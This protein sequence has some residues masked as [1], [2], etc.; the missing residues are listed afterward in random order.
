MIR[1][2]YILR[3]WN[4]SQEFE[5]KDLGKS[6]YCLG[7]EFT[8]DENKIAMHHRGNIQDIFEPFGAMDL[9]PVS[10]DGC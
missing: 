7:I 10:F 8:R 1:F 3:N 9:N 6:K 4:V 5:V 2:S